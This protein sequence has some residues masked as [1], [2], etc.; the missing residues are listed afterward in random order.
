MK[1]RNGTDTLTKPTTKKF[2]TKRILLPSG[3][4]TLANPTKEK[5][6]KKSLPLASKTKTPEK[7]KPS[8]T[9]DKFWWV[10]SHCKLI[11]DMG[12]NCYELPMEVGHTFED[13]YFDLILG[14]CVTEAVPLTEEEKT[15]L[16]SFYPIKTMVGR[17][18]KQCSG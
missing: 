1:L 12:P 2:A 7:P 14:R 8:F 18:L 6:T 17:T 13:G 11:N 4:Q 15:R 16:N 10:K 9:N 3:T 5:L